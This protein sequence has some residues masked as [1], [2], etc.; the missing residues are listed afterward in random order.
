MDLRF[1]DRTLRR[2]AATS[3][4]LA[5]LT[6]LMS[7]VPAWSQTP[8]WWPI[9]VK[10]FYGRYDAARK[11]PGKPSGSLG[12][13]R[14]E[15]WVPPAPGDTHF[16]I[17]VSFPHLKDSYWEAVNYGIIEEARRLGMGITMVEA[18][19][20]GRLHTQQRQ[21]R[22]LVRQ[23]VDGIILG[24][25]SYSGNDALI[26][27]LKRQGIPVV[28]AINDVKAPAVAAKAMVSFYEMGYFAGEFVATHAENAHRR[29]LRISFFPGPKDSGW[30]PDT[31][32]GFLDAMRHFPGTMT[33]SDIRWGDTGLI[34]QRRLL[35]QSLDETGP[36]DYIVG[37][38][39]AAEAAPPILKDRGA[40]QTHVVSTYMV[41]SLYDQITGR[42]VLAAPS[43]L[44]VFQ[45]RMAVD[46]LVRTLMGETPG[47]DFAYRSGPFIP[48]ITP[49]SIERF[50]YDGL[51]GPRN[52]KPV[53]KLA[54]EE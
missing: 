26:A 41:P 39:V 47:Q 2:L 33:F 51:F 36:V 13:A 28:A 35:N 3:L 22:W 4:I 49:E 27:E 12:R 24:S 32:Q 30:A 42:Q 38:A 10:S 19:G 48:M 45:G 37:N 11:I 31:L 23:K 7:T 9:Q 53:F 46:M 1:I 50:P 6:L 40:T 21:L 20:Y 34:A 25:I 15:E 5:T 14:L 29:H 8:S 17:G 54:T 16:T 43:D 18:G 44:T 52:Y